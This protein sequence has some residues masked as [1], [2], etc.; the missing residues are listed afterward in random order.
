M[1]FLLPMMLPFR[2]LLFSS[3]HPI[4]ILFHLL[5]KIPGGRCYGKPSMGVKGKEVRKGGKE[6][7]EFLKWKGKKMRAFSFLITLH[8][9]FFFSRTSKNLF[10]PPPKESPRPRFSHPLDIL[11]LLSFFFL[12][13]SFSPLPLN[14]LPF[15][16]LG[17]ICFPFLI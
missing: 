11:G 3:L 8:L 6:D 7:G 15:F 14:I 13:F 12:L 4:A 2:T 10:S 1:C 9:R 17:V 5:L 16:S